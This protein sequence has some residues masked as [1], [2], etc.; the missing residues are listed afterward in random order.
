MA[1]FSSSQKVC[2]G[3]TILA[4]MAG[5]AACAAPT[6]PTGI[7][8]PHEQSNRKVHAFNKK[9]A[10][11]GNG[12]GIA[13]AV[14]SEFQMVIHNIAENMAMPQVAVNSVL[15]GDLAGFG[16]ATSRFAVNTVLGFGGM[17]DAAGEFKMPEHDTDFGET[18]YV[19]GVGEGPYYELPLIGP[20]TRRDVAGR[21][22]DQFTNPL[23]Y[24][25]E[26][27]EKYVGTVTRLADS[28]FKNSR[29]SEAGADMLEGS[30]DSYAQARL[31]YLQQRRNALSQR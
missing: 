8:D 4:V 24:V 29:R 1:M 20:A 19:W 10:G 5:L 7:N 23:S 11:S 22:V 31:I 9:L 2:K 27:P 12:G 18:L 28:A 17:V 26:S 13:K 14:P 21:I 16:R 3:L 15:Q 6:Q 25:L 30:T